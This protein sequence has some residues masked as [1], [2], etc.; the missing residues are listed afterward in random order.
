MM[1]IYEFSEGLNGRQYGKEL[2][3]FE[4]QRAKQL[5]YVVV[6]GYSDDNTEFRGAIEDEVGCYDGGR[7]YEDGE[8]YVDAVWCE[9]EYSWTYRTNIPHA[10]FDIY[11]GCELYCRG[12]VFEQRGAE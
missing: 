2:Y 3:P 9:G 7:V 1:T 11:E 10:T 12:I 8:K 5:G 6:F 4:E